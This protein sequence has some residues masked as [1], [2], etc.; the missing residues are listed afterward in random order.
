MQLSTRIDTDSCF[1]SLEGDLDASSSILVDK[2]LE[3]IL[4]REQKFILVN[5]TLL[6]YISA[7]GIGAFI[8]HIRRMREQDKSIVF[9]SMSPSIRNIFAVTGLEEVIPIASSEE[10]AR[11]LCRQKTCN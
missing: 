9:Y 3:D 4:K 2:L 11:L 1:I 6:T 8:Y 7:A 5:F 10:D